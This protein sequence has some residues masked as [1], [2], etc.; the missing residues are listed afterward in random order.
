MNGK[1]EEL[2]WFKWAEICHQC[3]LHYIL[4]K[5]IY[6]PLGV[7]HSL[8]AFFEQTRWNKLEFQKLSH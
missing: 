6:T 3:S 8:L 2:A 4:Q 7:A 5:T 1:N